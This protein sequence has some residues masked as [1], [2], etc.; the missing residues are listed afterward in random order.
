[1]IKII[2]SSAGV[3]VAYTV[4]IVAFTAV[5]LKYFFRTTPGWF[6]E[7]VTLFWAVILGAVAVLTVKDISIM[8][9][10]ACL[11]FAMVGYEKILKRVVNFKYDDGKGLVE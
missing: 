5:T 4:A 10:I 1:M 2:E 7:V 6:K 3:Y 9:L 11:A 8:W